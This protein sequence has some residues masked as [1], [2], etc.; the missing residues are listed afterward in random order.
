MRIGVV[1]EFGSAQRLV[2]VVDS[3][4][5]DLKL[6]RKTFQGMQENQQ[7]TPKNG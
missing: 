3:T 6:G 5:H 7:P 1:V 2:Q 4:W